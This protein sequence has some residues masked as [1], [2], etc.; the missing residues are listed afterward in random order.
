MLQVNG[1]C[2]TTQAII[3][4]FFAMPLA[5]LTICASMLYL[6]LKSNIPW[7]WPWSNVLQQMIHF[8][9]SAHHLRC[10]GWASEAFGFPNCLPDVASFSINLTVLLCVFHSGVGLFCWFFY[11]HSL[12]APHCPWH[13]NILQPWFFCCSNLLWI[14]LRCSNGL[15][16]GS[17]LDLR[18]FTSFLHSILWLIVCYIL[19]LAI[20]KY[21]PD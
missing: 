5:L 11:W 8:W 14:H 3:E 17:A 6:T 7:T 21:K 19:L 20:K 4:I 15:K 2:A 9:L 13:I 16:D 10:S 1:C 12:C 18:K